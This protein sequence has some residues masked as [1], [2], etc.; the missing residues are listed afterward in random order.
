MK[1]S[2][3]CAEEIQDDAIKCRYCGEFIVDK[4]EEVRERITIGKKV[5]E[6]SSNW[7]GY[8]GFILFIGFVIIFVG[9]GTISFDKI[10]NV[11]STQDPIGNY[12]CLNIF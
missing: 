8:L 7:L 11:F 9:N 3:Y 1:N 12:Y 2:P 5:E 6:S 4:K 10:K